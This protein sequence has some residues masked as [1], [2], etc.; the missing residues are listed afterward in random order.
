M[1]EAIRLGELGRLGA[2]PNPWVG[3]VIV[4]N[5]Q[6]IGKGYHQRCGDAHAERMA[7]DSAKDSVA[8]SDM[9]VTLEPCCH[10]GQTPPCTELIIQSRI[11]RVFIAVYDPDVRVSSQGVRRLQAAGIDVHVGIEEDLARQSL[12]PYLH[13]RSNQQQ[14]WIVLKAALSLDGQLADKTGESKWITCKDAREHVGVLRARSQAV[15]VGANTVIQDNPALTARDRFG[16]LLPFQP[17]RVVLDSSGRVP[18]QSKLFQGG[19]T[20]YATTQH[21]PQKRIQHLKSFGVDCAIFDGPQVDLQQLVASLGAMGCLQ[22]L[23]EG[24]RQL[25]TSFLSLELAHSFILYLGP[26][27]LSDQ[28]MSVFGELP[29]NLHTAKQVLIRS[30][31]KIGHSVCIT[32]DLCLA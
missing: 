32:A 10:H 24:G 18:L 29:M 4:K 16:N 7:I 27:I 11:A 26:K 25:Y 1:R 31:E 5:G 19:R 9:Y 28:N 3:C 14:P 21:C 6:I 30:A 8:G 12:Q 23:V 17:L 22:I 20:L 2:P 13:H 15:L